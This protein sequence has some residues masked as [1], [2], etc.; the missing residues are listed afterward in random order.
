[1]FGKNAKKRSSLTSTKKKSINIRTLYNQFSQKK[2]WQLQLEF[3]LLFY[4]CCHAQ[5]AEEKE[6]EIP[7]KVATLLKRL[8]N[9]HIVMC[10][11][12]QSAAVASLCLNGKLL[13][14][15]VTKTDIR[16]MYC[17]CKVFEFIAR[18]FDVV[19]PAHVLVPIYHSICFLF[20]RKALRK[21]FKIKFSLRLS[22]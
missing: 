6:E 14:V 4:L 11:S 2:N 9:D 22:A 19:L 5:I 21:Y 12:N 17:D 16:S 20:F 15:I 18:T 8:Q 1:M 10:I 13:S 3:L 7:A